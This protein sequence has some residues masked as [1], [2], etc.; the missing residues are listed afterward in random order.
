MADAYFH[1]SANM[2]TT[3]FIWTVPKIHRVRAWVT[4]KLGW[5]DAEVDTKITPVILKFADRNQTRID[6]FFVTY[7]DKE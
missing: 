3:E 2:D 6:S 1:P 7:E 4:A 5:T